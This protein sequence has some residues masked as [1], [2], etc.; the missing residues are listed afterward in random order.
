MKLSIAAAKSKTE[1]SFSPLRLLFSLL[2]YFR[3]V[4]QAG[5]QNPSGLR[6]SLLSQSLG[7][8]NWKA[9]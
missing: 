3:V 2:S 5:L 6:D 8:L 4:L 7:L 9:E 1:F